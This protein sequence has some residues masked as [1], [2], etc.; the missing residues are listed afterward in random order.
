MNS[1]YAIARNTFREIIRDRILVGI[2]VFALLLVCLSV[3]LGQ[4]TFT[5]HARLSANF[6]LTGI[7]ISV[8][9][10]SIFVGS[11][12]VSREIEKQ[13]VL[14]LLARPISRT[15]FVLGKFLGLA[16][17]EIAIMLGLSIVLWLLVSYLGLSFGTA[18]GIALFGIFL[19][20]LLMTSV[21][22]FFGSFAKPMMTVMFAVSV[23]LGGHWVQ[24][25]DFFIKKSNSAQ[26]TAVASL[27]SK[28]VP[29]LEQVNWRSAPIYQTVIPGQEIATSFL[30][31]L[32]WIVC[33]QTFTALI[34]RNRDFV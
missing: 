9:V 23:F 14:T 11:T 7:H 33:L 20:G 16:F 24:S 27:V 19:E 26:F 8:V 15:Q 34:F 12:L 17:V 4:L 21:T 18:F 29:D 25:L 3:V 1:I 22:M 10:L 30:Y 13:T 28:V 32:I 5:E 2:L 6:G 31:I